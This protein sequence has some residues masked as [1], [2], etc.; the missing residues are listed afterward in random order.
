MKEKGLIK[1]GPVTLAVGLIAGGVVALLYNFGAIASLES[2]WKLWPVL[3]IGVGLEYFI[4]KALNREEAVHFHVPSILL[5]VLMILA[6]G[7]LYAATNISRNFGGILNGIPWHQA[8]LSFSRAWESDPVGMKAGEKL[9][10]A[11]SVGKVRLISAGGEELNV[12]ALIRSPQSGPGRDAAEEIN[13][14]IERNG[15]QVS[16]RV[17]ETAGYGGRSLATDLEVAVPAGVDVQIESATGRVEAENLEGSL[18]VNTNTGSVELR[19][20]GGN[21]E[22]RNNTGRVE[23]NEP[24]GS[25]LAKTTTGSVELSS[26]RPLSG[27]YELESNTGRVSLQ[28]PKE[29]DLAISAVSRTGRVS[30][31]GLSEAKFSRSGPPGD[32]FSYTLGAG[33]G[34]ANLQ[35][36]T[37]GISIV[38][39]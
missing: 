21:L 19:K 17:P 30:V 39:R 23:I 15:N 34:R 13:P 2:L 7:T 16:V 3:F 11:S 5:I 22:V 12:K 29:S 20:I 4:K 24:G 25:V 10:I 27:N 9:L 14:E 35:V 32:A 37:G 8:D 31:E 33:K 1:A 36:G 38:V 28:L 26:S 18:V 6:G